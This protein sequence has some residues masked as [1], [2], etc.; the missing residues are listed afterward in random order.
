MIIDLHMHST[1][2][3]GAFTPKEL[4]TIC[5]N[6][7][8]TICSLT[9]HDS[10]EGVKEA[11]EMGKKIGVEVI[12]GIEIACPSSEM[13]AYFIN[14]DSPEL[15]QFLID[16][17]KRRRARSLAVL[18]KVQEQG[19]DIRLEDLEQKYGQDFLRV[20]IAYAMVDKGYFKH[21]RDIFDTLFE[22]GQP[23]YVPRNS[24]SFEE[25]MK[26]IKKAQG[27]PVLAHPQFLDEPEKMRETLIKLKKLG[28]IG[29]EIDCPIT[30]PDQKNYLEKAQQLAQ[31]L[32]LVPTGGSDYHNDIWK[33]NQI[34]T[35][36]TTKENFEKLKAVHKSLYK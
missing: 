15:N 35:H 12:P 28:L 24:H 6:F 30:K 25:V 5:K 21:H 2:S 4:I 7:G 9:D 16:L 20:H 19:Y 11:I 8:V 27:I 1:A 10:V 14:I 34:G 31:E 32:D 17:R 33:G 18:K 29:I 13:L 23:C 3:D 26:A 36:T 22:E